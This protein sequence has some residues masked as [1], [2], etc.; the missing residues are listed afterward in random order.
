MT[1]LEISAAERRSMGV[2]Y[3]FGYDQHD[4]HVWRWLL[5]EM[6]RYGESHPFKVRENATGS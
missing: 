4:A 2:R 3:E 6:K 1:L 5:Y